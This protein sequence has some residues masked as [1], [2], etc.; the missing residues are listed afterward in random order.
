[1]SAIKNRIAKCR[2][3]SNYHV[4][5]QFEDGLQGTVDL[6]DLLTN[7]AFKRAWKSE[8]DFKQVRVDSVTHTI[9]WGEEGAEVDVNPSSLRAEI[10]SKLDT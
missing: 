10:L 3:E 7:P 8:E 1:M 5:I 4:W 9:T 6:R 2:A